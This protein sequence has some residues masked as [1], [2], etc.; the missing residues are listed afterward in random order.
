VPVDTMRAFRRLLGWLDLIKRFRHVCLPTVARCGYRAGHQSSRFVVIGRLVLSV[1]DFARGSALAL[2]CRHLRPH[3]FGHRR[4]DAA[5]RGCASKSA[6]WESA[7]DA[8]RVG[9]IV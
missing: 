7:A 8:G 5:L 9:L 4:H 2:V 3:R 6:R 1:S